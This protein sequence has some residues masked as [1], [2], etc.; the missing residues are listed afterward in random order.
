MCAGCHLLSGSGKNDGSFPQLAG[1]HSSV[2]I[3]Q[4]DDIKNGLRDNP[5]MYP[6]AAALTDNQ[7]IIDIATCNN[8][9]PI[10]E[11]IKNRTIQIIKDTLAPTKII[12]MI[13]F[14]ENQNSAGCDNKISKGPN[15]TNVITSSNAETTS[16][17]IYFLN[18][19]IY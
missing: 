4:I 19:F 10:F 14:V 3:K 8:L 16:I 2:I 9:S 6:F 18:S 17:N 7:K 1:Q 11:N 5:P 13:S 12:H 15:I